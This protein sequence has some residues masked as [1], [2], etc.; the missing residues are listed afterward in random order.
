MLLSEPDQRLV[1]FLV[2]NARYLLPKETC[3]FYPI[4]QKDSIDLDSNLYQYRFPLGARVKGASFVRIRVFAIR[5]TVLVLAYEL[6]IDFLLYVLYSI[7]RYID[8]KHLSMLVNG[9]DFLLQNRLLVP[10]GLLVLHR[11]TT[12]SFEMP[13]L[14]VVIADD[15]CLVLID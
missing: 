12:L 7:A 1:E 2:Y 8:I 13:L 11:A 9:H 6:P 4:L 15:I 5:Q 14:A 3:E 10:S